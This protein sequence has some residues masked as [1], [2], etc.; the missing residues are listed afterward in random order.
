[1]PNSPLTRLTS[2]AIEVFRF[3]ETQQDRQYPFM[4]DGVYD[5]IQQPFLLTLQ[6]SEYLKETIPIVFSEPDFSS[7]LARENDRTPMLMTVNGGSRIS[8]EVVLSGV[9][10]SARIQILLFNL[11]NN[12]TTFVKTVLQNYEELR[13]AVTGKK[14]MAYYVT[15][16]SGISL[17]AAAKASTPWGMLLPAPQVR[18]QDTPF[19][20]ERL[21]TTCTLVEQK[22]L[23]VKF[24]LSAQPECEFDRSEQRNPKSSFLFALA[25]ALSLDFAGKLGGPIET[26][27]T[28]FLP[29][30]G[31]HGGSFPGRQQIVYEYT[32]IDGSVRELESW[33]KTVDA[34]YSG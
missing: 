3:L 30:F 1:M 2:I 33:S 21:K 5:A 6:L 18:G 7:I 23:S 27:S 17:S 14:V 8:P 4:E 12:E 9:L 26:W 29:F 20:I 15:G 11:P 24:D 13:K 22:T 31:A 32:N 34:N 10:A 25:C 19:T 28:S 16:I